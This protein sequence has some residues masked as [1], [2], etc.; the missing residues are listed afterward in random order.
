MAESWGTEFN[1]GRLSTV[2]A[3]L[4][5]LP[6]QTVAEDPRLCL[7]RTWIALDRGR[8]EEAAAWIEAAQAGLASTRGD[9]VTIEA[10][11]TVLRAVQRFKVGDVDEALDVARRA[12]HLDPGDSPLGR[13]AAY[14]IYGAT[15]YWS[16]HTAE[17]REALG[18]AVQLADEVENHLG[19]TYAL[20]Y[21]AVIAIEQGDLAEAER[22][23]ELATRHNQDVG[24]SEHFVAMIP[25][26]ALAEIL[27]QKGQ[28]ELADS[29]AQRAVALSRR[30]GGRLE[31][32]KARQILDQRERR[33]REAGSRHLTK[34]APGEALTTRELEVLRLLRSSLSLREI[35]AHLYVSPNTVK[36]HQRALYRKLDVGTRAKAIDRARELGVL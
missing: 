29:A 8:L 7:A 15:L 32:A 22:L 10:E 36:S 31:A 17:A 23:V 21:L 33:T 14:C 16:G 35:G 25:A 9:R 1:R 20:G 11:V 19:R 3:W 27:D 30:G 26:L 13:S 18:R 12:I 24:V 4:D 2:S 6:Q 5:L 28:T 34:P